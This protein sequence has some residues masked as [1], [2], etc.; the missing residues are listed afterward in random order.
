MIRSITEKEEQLDKE[1]QEIHITIWVLKDILSG[2]SRFSD[3]A[4]YLICY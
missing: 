2:I 4:G 1:C 3:L